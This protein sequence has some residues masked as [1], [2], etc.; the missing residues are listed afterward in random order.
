MGKYNLHILRLL[1][2]ASSIVFG[3]NSGH[4][5]GFNA[6]RFINREATK[7]LPSPL[8]SFYKNFADYIEEHA[9]DPDKRRYIDTNEA[10]RHYIDLEYYEQNLPIDT[11]P[12]FWKG[13]LEKYGSSYLHDFGSLPWQIQLSMYRLRKA[14]QAAELKQ[15]IQISAELGHYVADA[16]VPLHTTANYDGQL[17]N[18]RGIH[19]LWETKIPDILLD[20]YRLLIPKATFWHSESDSIFSI[21]EESHQLISVV[22][23]AEKWINSLYAP[24][25]RYAFSSQPTT[26]KPSKNYSQNYLV[27]CDKAME[28]TVA[29]RLQSAIFR[30]ASC[31]YTA[32]ILAGQPNLPVFEPE[33]SPTKTKLFVRNQPKNPNFPLLQFAQKTQPDKGETTTP[34]NPFPSDSLEYLDS[35]LQHGHHADNCHKR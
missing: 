33:T 12:R 27:N 14:F 32:W 11:I 28:Y 30:V 8:F 15:I 18:Q 4:T 20:E 19:A 23:Q 16:H 6:H 35:L 2:V 17:T 26:G 21:I 1:L 31:W 5:W 22:L 7:I 3:W 13:A 9:V 34:M 29:A 24:G 25:E 10:P